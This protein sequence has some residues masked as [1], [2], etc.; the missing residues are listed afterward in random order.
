MSP[1]SGSRVWPRTEGNNGITQPDSDIAFPFIYIEWDYDYK[2]KVFFPDITNVD[3]F[4]FPTELFL[5]VDG[6]DIPGY[7]VY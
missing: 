4:S 5:N 6:L 3:S 1:K 2:N 7:C